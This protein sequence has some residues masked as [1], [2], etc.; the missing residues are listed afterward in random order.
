M[1]LAARIKKIK[2][3]VV[4]V[5]GVLTDGKI[6]F[7]D[8]GKETKNFNVYDGFALVFL[9]RAGFKTAIITARASK[10]VT[11]RAKDLNIDRTYQDAFP[12]LT[13]Y[14]KFLKEFHLKDENICF[15]ADDLPD[16]QVLKRVGFAVSVLNGVEEIKREAHYITKKHGGNGAVREAVELILKTQGKWNGVLARYE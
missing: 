1:P 9:K 16:L 10:T 12:K 5:D 15:I 2:A 3:V 13:A 11:L 7:D 8:A 6:I 4:D 14:K